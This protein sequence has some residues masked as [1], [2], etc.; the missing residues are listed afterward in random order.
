MEDRIKSWTTRQLNGVE[1]LKRYL[2]LKRLIQLKI[3]KVIWIYRNV[4]AFEGTNSV[5]LPYDLI[6]LKDIDIHTQDEKV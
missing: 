1:I 2:E 5:I 4:Y 6:E 3:L